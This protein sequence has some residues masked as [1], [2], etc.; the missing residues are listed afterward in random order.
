[1]CSLWRFYRQILRTSTDRYIPYH[2]YKLPNRISKDCQTL[3]RNSNWCQKNSTCV[4]LWGWVEKWVACGERWDR[5]IDYLRMLDQ[6]GDRPR[7]CLAVGELPSEVVREL[8]LL[9]ARRKFCAQQVRHALERAAFKS[10]GFRAILDVD[11][12]QKGATVMCTSDCSM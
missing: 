8:R 9:C 4:V 11:Y 6:F 2:R 5:R 7:G 10:S 3:Y 12:P 1:M